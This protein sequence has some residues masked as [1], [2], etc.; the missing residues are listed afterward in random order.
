MSDKKPDAL[1]IASRLRN[2]WANEVRH[3]GADLIERQH[4]EIERLRAEL[5]R[6]RAQEPVARPAL[7]AGV[8]LSRIPPEVIA[9]ALTLRKWADENN[10][11]TPWYIADIGDVRLAAPQPAPVAQLSRRSMIEAFEERYQSDWND[12]AL[13]QETEHWAAA[14]KSAAQLLTDEPEGGAA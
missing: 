7:P 12:P 1:Q 10:L 14:W 8:D 2:G 4:A 3:L 13:R 5:D 9:A 6:L 11:T